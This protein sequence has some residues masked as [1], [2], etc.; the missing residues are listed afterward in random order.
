MQFVLADIEAPCRSTGEG[1]PGVRE[2]VTIPDLV[3]LMPLGREAPGSDARQLVDLACRIEDVGL[4]GIVLADHVVMGSTTEQ[5]PWG[6]FPVPSDT[7]F[8]EPLTLL[9][10]IASRTRRIRVSSG[11]VIAPL[12]PAALLAKTVATLDQ[13][14]AGRLDLGVGTGWQ[15]AEFDAAGLS[16]KTRGPRLTEIIE[17]CHL[18]WTGESVSFHGQ[19]VHFENVICRPLPAQ[20][21][22]PPV[23][24]SGTLNSTNV[25]RVV[26]LGTG[27][28]PI[29][30]EHRSG[31]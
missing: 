13:I 6:E 15:L 29:M 5:Y 12:R 7:P 14:S 10:A 17:A 16:F 30:G 24:F 9:A 27:W 2:L 11:I 22:G 4:S 26:R 20:A 28:I 23:F 19:Y 18:L 8:F 25:D 31:I 21:G 3:V 1:P